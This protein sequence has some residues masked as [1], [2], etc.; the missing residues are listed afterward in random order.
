MPKQMQHPDTV[1]R[2]DTGIIHIVPIMTIVFISFLMIG[3]A[4]PVLPLHVHD[5]LKLNSSMIGIVAG[6]QFVASL[7]SRL[8][9]GN[10]SDRKGPKFAILLG[11]W[12]S[13]L[14]NVLYWISNYLV[15]L[16]LFSVSILLFGRVCLGGAESLIITGG[17]LWAL[18]L[19]SERFAGKVISWVGMSMFAAMAVGAPI[20]HYI[21]IQWT[22][23]GVAVT[24]IAL[25]F[26]SFACVSAS[27]SIKIRQKEDKIAV[28]FTHIVKAV[29]IPGLS[30]ALS[31]LTF[32]AIT[33]FLV[34][35]FSLNDWPDGALAFSLFAISIILT[36][37]FLGHC[38][39]RFGGAQT[40]LFSLIIQCAGLFIIVVAHRETIA[41]A[42]T[43]C[44]GTGFS[45]VF[46]GLGREVINRVSNQ[47]RGIAMGTYNAFLDLT[48]GVGCPF[49]GVLADSFG[50]GFIF[51]L[52][53][54]SALLAVLVILPLLKT[55]YLVH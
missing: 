44:A 49:L 13:L 2:Q 38:P 32:G 42:G 19:V 17:M 51:L 34:L 15:P 39:D 12:L 53:G 3:M 1:F 33:S 46:P 43:I 11:L 4:I 20:G 29:C 18:E 16:P 21:Y 40:A 7:L 55:S 8:W 10:L 36:R 37:V 54:I 52:S 47:N 14:G 48:L 23:S 22:F 27:K 41:I 9:A 45:L 6:G 30:F 5:E 24:S 28:S 26:A 50:I 25:C 31:G 35:Y